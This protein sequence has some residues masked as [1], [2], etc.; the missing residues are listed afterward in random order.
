MTFDDAGANRPRGAILAWLA[1]ARRRELRFVD[2][3]GVGWEGSVPRTNLLR[4]ISTVESHVWRVSRCMLGEG[5]LLM[6]KAES[7]AS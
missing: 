7:F 2:L 3:L 4:S 1:A 5:Q 6:L